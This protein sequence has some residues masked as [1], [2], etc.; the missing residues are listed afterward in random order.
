MK[1]PNERGDRPVSTL[2]S[3]YQVGPPVASTRKERCLPSNERKCRRYSGGTRTL[4]AAEM[5]KLDSS[6]TMMMCG[7]LL[8]GWQVSAA[9]SDE[10]A[11]PA[12]SASIHPCVNSPDTALT[13]E[14]K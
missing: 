3:A 12:A 11:G 1:R 2:Y 4:G 10:P 8:A 13:P 6:S 14:R 7:R 9:A 5:S